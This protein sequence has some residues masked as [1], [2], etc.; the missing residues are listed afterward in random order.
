MHDPMAE[1]IKKKRSGLT[2][3]IDVSPEGELE[4][5]A[6]KGTDL[7]PEAP[8]VSEDESAEAPELEA[9]EQEQ[10]VDFPMADHI[11]AEQAMTGRPPKSLFDRAAAMQAASKKQPKQ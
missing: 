11:A 2:I 3:S 10:G 5:S 4:T 7:A 9:A 6:L 8:E 1:A